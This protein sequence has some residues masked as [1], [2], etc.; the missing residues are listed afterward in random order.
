MKIRQSSII[1]RLAAKARRLARRDFL[2]LRLTIFNEKTWPEKFASAR[3]TVA[4]AVEKGGEAEVRIL[5]FNHTPRIGSRL[6]AR[7][8]EKSLSRGWGSGGRK[9]RCNY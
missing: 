9:K 5:F 2:L 7:E 4:A 3:A 6:L 8:R 1:T